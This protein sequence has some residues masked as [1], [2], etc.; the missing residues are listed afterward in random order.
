MVN[1]KYRLRWKKP[2][3]LTPEISVFELKSIERLL[4]TGDEAKLN[5]VEK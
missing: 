2:S 1:N 4:I 3:Y 5:K